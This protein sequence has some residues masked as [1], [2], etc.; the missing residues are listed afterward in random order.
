MPRLTSRVSTTQA[1]IYARVSSEQQA[2][3]H[4]IDS[5]VSA[6]RTRV[7]ADGYALPPELAFLDDGYSG[8]TLVRPALERLRDLI[9]AGGV[10]VLYVHSPD[11]LARKYAYQVLLVE[12]FQR[13]GV[14]VIF[15]NRA[16]GESPEDDLLLQVQ[17]VVAEYERAKIL[18]RSRRGKRHAAQ[19]GTVSVLSGAPYGYRYVPKDATDAPARYEVHDEAAAVI[20]QIFEWIGRERCSIGEVARRLQQTGTPS[21]RGKPYWDRSTIW[22]LLRN[23]AYMGQAAYGKTKCVARRPRVR[24]PRGHS[25][26]PRVPVSTTELPPAEWLRIAVPALVPAALFESVQEQLQQNR[27]HARS[28][29]QGAQHLLQ[30]L[31]VCAQCGYAYYVKPLSRAAAKGKRYRYVYYRCIGADAYRFGGI[32]VCANRQ[33]NG[34]M[35]EAAVWQEVERLLEDPARVLREHQRRLE[36]VSAGQTSRVAG[37]TAQ[38]Q[39]LRTGLARLID[40]YADGVITKVEFEPRVAQVRERIARNEAQLQEL[41]TAAT[42]Q[43][44]LALAVG[45]LDAFAAQLR[46]GLATTDGTTRREIVRTL[47]KRVEVDRE[48]VRV[49]FRI[50]ETKPPPG[51]PCLPHCGRRHLAGA[52]EHGAGRPGTHAP[53]EVPDEDA[54]HAPRDGQRHPIRGRLRD[55]RVLARAPGDRG[56]AAHRGVPR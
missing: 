4:T 36:G 48:H 17:G 21:P 27:A 9:A 3:A 5:Q 40:S 44:D 18:E 32:R 12:E 30:G 26:E 50:D 51:D 8:A 29:R 39:R 35:L 31:V 55:H 24:A 16:V 49:V 13:L 42:Q 25:L 22:G 28:R 2:T 38:L 45:K 7:A 53:S 6:L 1:A 46:D 23:P 11:R 56:Q 43:A 34:A 47:V 41:A 52:G 15:L 10:D 37:L 14:E 54:D 19:L 33:V 20:R